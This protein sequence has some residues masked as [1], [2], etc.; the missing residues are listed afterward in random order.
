[1]FHILRFSLK[2]LSNRVKTVSCLFLLVWLNA[3]AVYSQQAEP[4]LLNDIAY[5]SV[6]E[7]PIVAPTEV[8]V[9]GSADTQ[10]VWYYQAN[11]N[12]YFKGVVVLIHGGCWLSQFT[13]EHTQALSNALSEQ[14]YAIWNIEYR[15]TGNG[16]EWPVALDDIRAGI[17]QLAVQKSNT[18]DLSKIN[19]VGHSA[20]GHLAML[21]AANPEGLGLPP[22][23][24]LTTIA[25]APIVDIQAYSLGTNSCQSAT[26][27]FMQGSADERAA[28]YQQASVLNYQFENSSTY[29]LVGGN[30]KIVASEYSMHPDAQHIIVADA[31]HFDWIHPGTAAFKQLSLVLAK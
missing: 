7:L 9:Y 25:L 14:G 22:I 20:G 16:G 19:L 24:K 18:L 29:V 1:M 17:A 30:D 28:E 15:S 12:A 13:I 26:A 5:S 8:I 10:E 3:C 23:S 4:A 21:A 31:G 6:L 27:K 2:Q 11:P